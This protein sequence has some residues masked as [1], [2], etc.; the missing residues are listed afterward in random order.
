M[1]VASGASKARTTVPAPIPGSLP[2]SSRSTACSSQRT[3]TC[4]HIA[5]SGPA[6]C[7]GRQLALDHVAQ[8][9]HDLLGRARGGEGGPVNLL[10]R[11]VELAVVKGDDRLPEGCGEAGVE[12]GIP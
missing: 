11:M 2:S 4:S 10:Q 7:S 3:N 8:H 1:P 9:V 5:R 6:D 12:G